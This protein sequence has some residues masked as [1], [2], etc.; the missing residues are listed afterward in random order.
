MEQQANFS[1]KGTIALDIDGTITESAHDLPLPVKNYLEKLAREGWCLLFLT[2]RTFSFASTVV[3]SLACPF[4]LGVQNGAALL[5]M[6]SRNCLFTN[7]LQRDPLLE[8]IAQEE[9]IGFLI[10]SGVL[11]NDICYYR[12]ED[13]TEEE[14][15]YL[16]FR[17]K[18]SRAPWEMLSSFDAL[19]IASF[20]VIK[21]FSTKEKAEAFKAKC[22]NVNHIT[23][24][25]PFRPPYYLTLISDKG[26]TK[27]NVL[28]KRAFPRPLIAA[29][30]DWNDL[31]LLK[32]AAIGIA[33]PHAPH[34][35]REVAKLIAN[36]GIVAALEEAIRRL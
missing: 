28:E 1:Y 9:G 5:E 15:V 11:N 13:F 17:K 33:M 18:I 31:G 32:V 21:Y 29:G 35:L 4:F 3:S 19:P 25:D 8:K 23:T 27:E 22:L 36:E 12:K 10:E 20:P 34:A 2:G 6:Q 7:Y 26:A 30:D 16:E 14:L 24:K